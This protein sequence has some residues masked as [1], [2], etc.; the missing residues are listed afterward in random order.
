MGHEKRNYD[1][2]IVMNGNEPEPVLIDDGHVIGSNDVLIFNKKTDGLK[3]VDHYRLTF[4]IQDFD[5]SPLRFVPNEKDVF[6]VQ[7]GEECPRDFS[8]LPGVIWVDHV[9]P[10]GKRIEVINMDM[11]ELRFQFT[12]N[13][14]DKNI[15]NPTKADYIALDP[16]GGNQNAGG[17]GS[18]FT[19]ESNLLAGGMAGAIVGLGAASFAAGGFVP[20]QALAFAAAGAVVGLTVG[21]VLDRF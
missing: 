17:P 15:A 9:H 20:A 3:K 7:A 6:W 18:G 10:K 13:F 2:K 8:E 14:V 21:L 19:F 16:G 4:E 12:L 5:D 1:I 11:T